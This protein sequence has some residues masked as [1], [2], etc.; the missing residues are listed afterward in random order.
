MSKKREEEQKIIA[1][2]EQ[3]LKAQGIETPTEK[4]EPS[5]NTVPPQA[6]S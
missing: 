4:R 6:S 1:E 2:M 5:M 3:A